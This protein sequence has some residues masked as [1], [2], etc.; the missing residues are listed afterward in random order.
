VARKPIARSTNPLGSPAPDASARQLPT[1]I[2]ADGGLVGSD[3]ASGQRHVELFRRLAAGSHR[4]TATTVQPAGVHRAPDRPEPTPMQGQPG[5]VSGISISGSGSPA[6][7][8]QCATVP[9]AVVASTVAC[10]RL[11]IATDVEVRRYDAE[12]PTASPD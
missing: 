5:S 1:V 7:G 12:A 6:E 10:H 11:P 8:G 4:R 2:A 3:A 9:A